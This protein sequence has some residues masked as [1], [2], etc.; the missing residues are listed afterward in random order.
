MASSDSTFIPAGLRL[1]ELAPEW[2]T[3][4]AVGASDLV[5]V[6]DAD[7]VIRD[8]AFGDARVPIDGAAEWIGRRWADT[9]DPESRGRVEL[10]VREAVA[11]GSSS[12]R[13]LSH[14]TG[15]GTDVPVSYFAARTEAGTLIAVGRD[16]RTVSALQRRLVDTQQAMERDY[17]RL[18]HLETRHRMLLQL[19]TDAILVLD[20]DSMRIVEASD[21]AALV[22]GVSVDGLVGSPFPLGI[23]A[24]EV[25]TVEALLATARA[26]GHAADTRVRL[27]GDRGEALV[28]VACL[29]QDSGTLLVVRLA[30]LLAQSTSLALR[31]A[32]LLELWS[33]APEA[34][35]V[36]DAEGQV[37]CANRAFLELA[38]LA[39]E[40]QAQGRSLGLWVGHPGADVGVFLATVRTHGV[41]RLATSSVRGALGLATE[42]ELSAVAL[43]TEGA[44]SVG[45]VLRDVGRRVAP[46]SRD[47]RD[48]TTAVEELCTMVGKVSLPSVVRDT[49]DLVERHFIE[50][51]LEL[52]GDNRTAAAEILGLS[53]QTLYVKMRRHGLAT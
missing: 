3:R 8:V 49:S 45:F 44:G 35:V 16:L 42:I 52:T 32:K 22:F 24:E 20:A 31:Q 51:A 39:S 15:A 47:P 29:R 1:S 11:R 37:L 27:A 7:T 19:T 41:V 36:T 10:I 25:R 18:R 14:A 53:R 40:E 33:R 28:S 4:I 46:S 21:A 50:A 6:L 43:P 38:Q 23:A 48:L 13:Q 12:E 5:L 34:L 17:T 2:A 26:A 9:V 30:R